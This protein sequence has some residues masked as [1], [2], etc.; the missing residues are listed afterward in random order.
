ML[1]TLAML[2]LPVMAADAP[3]SSDLPESEDVPVTQEKPV[4]EP[5]EADLTGADTVLLYCIDTD[6]VLREKNA[7]GKVY[8]ATAVKLMTALLAYEQIPD[9]KAEI[10]VTSE[11]LK[12]VSGGYYGFGAGDTVTGEDLIKL[13][14]LRKSNDAALIL[15]H[16]VSGSVEAFVTAMN[17]KAAE[18]GMADTFFVNPTGLHDNGMTTTA[19]DLLQLSMA[20]YSCPQLHEWSGAG[21]LSFPSIGGKTIY[22]NNYFLSRYYNGTGQDYL[23]SDVVD[24]M[25]NGSTA[26]AG[27]VLVTSATYKGLHYMVIVL[28]GK[29]V[30]ELPACYSITKQLIQKDTQNFRYL[31]VLHNAEVICELPVKFGDGVD[32]AAVFAK[33]TL[34]YYLPKSLQPDLIEKKVQLSKNSLDAPVHEGDRVGTVSVYLDGTLLGETDLVVRSNITRSG[35]EYRITQAAKFLQSEKF[36]KIATVVVVL[37]I[38]YV[39]TQAIYQGQKKKRYQNYQKNNW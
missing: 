26:Q 14:L 32:Y 30:D 5:I 18:L 19:R 38:V 29:T 39:L 9:L 33:E 35:A 22:N 2:L 37:G 13:L 11:M 8:P 28:G 7:D 25:I 24:G 12:G 36:L 16:T 34:E 10:T 27:D 6:T 23:Y 1:L 21:Y 4:K 17:E 15:A 31:K 20:F 3:E